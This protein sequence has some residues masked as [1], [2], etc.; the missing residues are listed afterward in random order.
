MHESVREQHLYLIDFSRT[1][2]TNL[3]LGLSRSTVK[4]SALHTEEK[5]SQKRKK[6]RFQPQNDRSYA[7]VVPTPPEL[8][9]TQ[10]MS[11]PVD[12]SVKRR[13]KNV[14]PKRLQHPECILSVQKQTCP[15]SWCSWCPASCKAFLWLA[16]TSG[17]SRN[18]S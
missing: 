8:K 12:K 5:V 1:S 18:I 16:P 10:V 6:K 3:G 15:C 2:L 4:Q 9:V 13:D 7:P 11:K 17:Q 14:S